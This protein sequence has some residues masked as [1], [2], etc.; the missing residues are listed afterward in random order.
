VTASQSKPAPATTPTPSGTT[1]AATFAAPVAEA[2][3][4]LE[5]HVDVAGVLAYQHG[6]ELQR[7]RRVPG[8][9]HFP[10]AIDPLVGVDPEDWIIVV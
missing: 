10:A 1:R 5:D 7:V 3:D 2:L 8:V 4:R 9:T 6:F